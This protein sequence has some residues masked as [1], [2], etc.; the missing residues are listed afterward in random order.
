MSCS[1]RGIL[2]ARPRRCRDRGARLDLGIAEIDQRR[3]RLRHRLRG[4]ALGKVGLEVDDGRVGA[5]IGRGLVAELG[6][7]ALRHLLADAGGAGEE[8]LVLERDGGGELA[9]LHDAEH[10]KRDLAADALHGLE[11]PEPLALEVGGEA[12]ETDDVLADIGLD[13]Q[14]HRLARRGQ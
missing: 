13:R 12:I 11:H 9:R 5:G 10:G 14:R 7:D 3:N 4:A 8:R 2:A 6:D 1:V